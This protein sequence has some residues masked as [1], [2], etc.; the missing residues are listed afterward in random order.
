MAVIKITLLPVGLF[1]KVLYL[2][3]TNSLEGC[4]VQLACSGPCSR[5]E[6]LCLSGPGVMFD[7]WDCRIFF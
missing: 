5:L 2:I 6:I 4:L 3:T 7:C 1:I